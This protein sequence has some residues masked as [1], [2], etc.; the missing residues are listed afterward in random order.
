MHLAIEPELVERTVFLATRADPQR[1]R[2]YQRAFAESYG[3][4]PGER[5]DQAFA[6]L[7]N[8]WFDE[9]GLRR[10]LLDRLHEFPIMESR[11][12]RFAVVDARSRSRSGAELFGKPASYAL[13]LALTPSL[14]LD[15]PAFDA[16]ARFELQ[17]IEDML[18]PAFGY[19]AARQPGGT[20]AAKANLVHDRFV[21]LWAL[22]IDARLS[23]RSPGSPNVSQTRF[24][25]I[26]RAFRLPDTAETRA[27]YQA[28]WS[29]LSN[30]LPGYAELLTWATSGIPDFGLTCSFDE[31]GEYKPVPGAR[32]PL[33][34]FTTF[35]WAD[36]AAESAGITEAIRADYPT[37]RPRQ[38]ICRRCDEVYRDRKRAVSAAAAR[39]QVGV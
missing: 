6:A 24:G 2:D 10:R 36:S 14:L 4:P 20:T 15:G 23:R 7:H 16:W 11:I 30:W 19:D 37:W 17:H 32:C 33:C 34:G 13:V 27:A 25:E 26:V 29:R 39:R 9:L 35:D 31:P 12:N 5:R 38:P 28:C 18:D 21:I 3:E 8:R 22:S 1:C